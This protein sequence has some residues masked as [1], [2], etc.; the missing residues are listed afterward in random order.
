MKIQHLELPRYKEL[1]NDMIQA[2]VV[3]VM[4]LVCAQALNKKNKEWPSR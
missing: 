2:N 4:E 3:G 1:K